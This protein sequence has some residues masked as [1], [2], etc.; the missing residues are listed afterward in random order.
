MT[1]NNKKV[2]APVIYNFSNQ[3]KNKFELFSSNF[4]ELL[5]DVNKCK[6]SFSVITEDFNAIS[7]S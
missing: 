2:I 5:N 6:L 4:K 7:F 1:Y 3:N